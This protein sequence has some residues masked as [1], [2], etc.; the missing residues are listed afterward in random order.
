M[1]IRTH[2]ENLIISRVALPGGTSNT[3]SRAGTTGMIYNV[4]GSERTHD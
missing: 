3:Q 4:T 1:V 2:A